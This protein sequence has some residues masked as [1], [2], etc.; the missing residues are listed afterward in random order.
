MDTI[1]VNKQDFLQVFQGSGIGK[2][3]K[4]IQRKNLQGKIVGANFA[5]K[6]RQMNEQMNKDQYTGPTL[7]GSN[8]TI[9]KTSFY[10]I[11]RNESDNLTGAP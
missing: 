2:I 7:Q 4:F 8:K 1:K 9:I 6:L 10:L 11:L 5:K 3:N